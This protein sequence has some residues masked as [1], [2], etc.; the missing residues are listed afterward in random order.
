MVVDVTDVFAELLAGNRGP[1]P[2]N[3]DARQRPNYGVVASLA[4]HTLS[5]VLTFRRGAA[6]CCLEWGCHLA[7]TDG[8]RWDALRRALAARGIVAPS[9]LELALSCVIE[10]GVVVYDT[11]RPDPTRLGRYAFEA[12]AAQHDTVSAIEADGQSETE[13]PAPPETAM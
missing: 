12:V 4:G 5:V 6:Y 2:L 1:E 10:E 8:R 9:R 11:S 7:L 13:P 3:P